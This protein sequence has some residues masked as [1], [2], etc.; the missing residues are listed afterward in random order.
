MNYEIQEG[1]EL[2]GVRIRIYPTKEQIIQLV[3]LQDKLRKCWNWLV[4][5]KEYA[6]EANYKWA[7]QS[8]LVPAC[9]SRPDYDKMSPEEASAAKKAHRDACFT[10]RKDAETQ[11]RKHLGDGALAYTVQDWCEHLNIKQDYQLLNK[12]LAWSDIECVQSGLLQALAK[13]FRSYSKGARR[14]KFKGKQD[15]IPIRT[16]TGTC[17]YIG[18]YG[19]RGRSHANG[20]NANYYD[21]RVHI[22]G[23]RILGRSSGVGLDAAWR[24][25]EGVAITE[26]AD[27]WWAAI[28]VERPKRTLPI[29][30]A[31]TVIG[32]DVGLRCMIAMSDGVKIP[33]P[34]GRDYVGQIAAQQ[35]EISGI[36]DPELRTKKTK[37]LSR[38]QQKVNLRI[39][40]EIY[41]SVLPALAQF[42]TIKMEKLP[43]Y[44]GQRGSAMTSVMRTIYRM[45]E[46]RYGDRV[47]EVE[48]AYTSQDCS[49]CGHRDKIAW[50]YGDNPM[51]QC[52]VCN[53][54]QDRDVNAAR[55]IAARP[56]LPLD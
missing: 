13:S 23:L 45:A 40:H 2:R 39:R 27:G 22:A 42:E 32:L 21:C 31:D 29:P 41:S 52:P 38:L 46:Q 48:P 30:V 12:M 28:K 16:C 54:R 55:N 10:I 24:V 49:N 47:R 15:H 35:K 51:C 5:Q 3:A 25:L 11:A 56:V 33:N 7:V 4:R 17:F 34:R 8:R 26:E 9:P 44:I 50:A 43:Q 36:E 37:Q 20:G 19:Q 18:S 1:N 6:R 53:Y 14:K